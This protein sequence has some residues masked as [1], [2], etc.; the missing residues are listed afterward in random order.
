MEKNLLTN[1]FSDTKK[2]LNLKEKYPLTEKI[3]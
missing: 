1:V 2:S 3:F